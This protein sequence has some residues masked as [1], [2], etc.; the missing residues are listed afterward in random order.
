MH[1][2]VIKVLLNHGA[3][4]HLK[5]I[6]REQLTLAENICKAVIALL[7]Q[8]GSLTDNVFTIEPPTI[9]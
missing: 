4:K 3:E 1:P 5:I 9:F 2:K 7:E 6:E 8:K